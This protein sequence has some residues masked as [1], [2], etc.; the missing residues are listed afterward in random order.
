MEERAG[1]YAR[2]SAKHYNSKDLTIEN[3][4]LIS[5]RYIMENGMILAGQYTDKG[6]SGMDFER[7]AWKTLLSDIKHQKLDAVI[8]KDFSRIGRNYI[9]TGE[10]I[11]K[12]FPAY[13]IRLIAV[14]EGYDSKDSSN[15]S[16]TGLENIINEWYA[17]ESGRKVSI[18]KQH[19]KAEGGY[20]GG[21]APYGFR[22]VLKDGIRVL[23]EG[24]SMK[25]LLKIH[26]LKNR[27]FTS[28]EVAEWLSSHKVNTPASYISTGQ[29]YCT[30]GTYKKWDAGSVRRL[31]NSYTSGD[32]HT[33]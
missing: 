24:E 8:V 19:L 27:G 9:E 6:F 32:Y 31:W 17:R 26:A 4:I 11:E 2:V 30:S 3:Q 10:Y 1:I 28:R 25:I 13:G 23:E 33:A 18:I 22:V 15:S 12:I 29:L 21:A 20:V 7:P 16:F 14:T 5:R